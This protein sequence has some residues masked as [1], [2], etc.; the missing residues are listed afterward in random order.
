MSPYCRPGQVFAGHQH[1]MFSRWQ[2]PLPALHLT[3]GSAELRGIHTL[4]FSVG[5]PTQEAAPIDHNRDLAPDLCNLLPREFAQ[6]IQILAVG[7]FLD[8]TQVN[9]LPYKDM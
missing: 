7:L 6:L 4:C 1:T 8:W 3:R 5:I 9:F 2:L